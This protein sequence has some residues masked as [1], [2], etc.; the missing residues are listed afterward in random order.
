MVNLRARQTRACRVS[1][2]PQLWR[3]WR[4]CANSVEKSDSFL[5]LCVDLIRRSVVTRI[6][7]KNVIP[8]EGWTK[9]LHYYILLIP[10]CPRGGRYL[11]GVRSRHIT[12]LLSWLLLYGSATGVAHWSNREPESLHLYISILVSCV[13][14]TARVTYIIMSYAL[15]MCAS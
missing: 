11:L 5:R 9:R 7:F 10:V 1:E 3:A 12:L 14:Y 13:Y 2:F 6:A 4:I 15:V 8:L